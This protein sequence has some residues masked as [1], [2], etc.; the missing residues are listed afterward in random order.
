[1]PQKRTVTKAFLLALLLLGGMI[2]SPVCAQYQISP[3]PLSGDMVVVPGQI[4][5][6]LVDV[7]PDGDAIHKISVD[8]PTGTTVDF[9]LTYGNGDTVSGWMKYVNNGFYQQTSEVSIGGDTSTFDYVGMQQIGRI[10]VVGY[11]RNYTDDTNYT[12]GFI[13]YDTVFGLTQFN[14]MAFYEV[15]DLSSNVIYKFELTSDQPV[16]VTYYSDTLATVSEYANKSP[17]EIINEWVAFAVS[18]ASFVYGVV[19][20]LFTWIKFFFVDNLL[21]TVS[22]YLALTMAYSFGRAKNMQ[23]GLTK[24]FR[25]QRA[26]FEF[27]LSLWN[28][29]VQILATFRGIFRI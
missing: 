2:V 16:S 28:Y 7:S 23:Q 18:M 5:Y 3:Q 15:P 1:M 10:D 21:M 26:F 24:F 8:I 27:I 29:L 11:A 22:L 20:A 6:L 12:S 17:L 9:T 13:V 19:V 14:A 4:T 25:F